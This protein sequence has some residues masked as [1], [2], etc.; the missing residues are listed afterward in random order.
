VLTHRVP[1]YDDGGLGAGV[2]TPEE[3]WSGALLR[4]GGGKVILAGP[5]L[6]DVVCALEAAQHVTRV[7]G[8]GPQPAAAAPTAAGAYALV[9]R[10]SG[11]GVERWVVEGMSPTE[12][13]ASVFGA[14]AR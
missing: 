8:Y 9:E 3:P 10:Y 7:D 5:A 11:P 6:L 14:E 12:L 13:Y 4:L 1:V 2:V